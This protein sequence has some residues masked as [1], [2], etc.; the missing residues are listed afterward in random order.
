MFIFIFLIQNIPTQS[1][2]AF[3]PHRCVD[4]SFYYSAG[5]WQNKITAGSFVTTQSLKLK[6]L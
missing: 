6:S 1:I 4:L 3:H 2:L 5:I